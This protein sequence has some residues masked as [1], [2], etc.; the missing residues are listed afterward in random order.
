MMMWKVLLVDDELHILRAA[1]YKLKMSGFEV[2]CAQ[3]G[4]EAWELINSESPDLVVTDLQ[5]PR[6]NGLELIEKIRGCEATAHLPIIMLTAKG[7]ELVSDDVARQMEV[8]DVVAK[9]FSPRELCQRIRASLE[10]AHGTHQA[11]KMN[12]PR[13]S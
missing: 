4:V 9:P 10:V 11:A 12:G 7:F 5:M 1:E 6:L 8:Y 2:F 3:D 13:V